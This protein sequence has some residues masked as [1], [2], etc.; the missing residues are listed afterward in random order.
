MNNY[1]FLRVAAAVPVVKVADTDTNADRICALISEA[2]S[3]EVS[4]VVFPE[5]SVTGYT[6]GDLFGQQL[7]VR[8][9]EKGCRQDNGTY[10]GKDIT[11]V[12]GAPVRFADRLY[13]CAVVIRNGNIKALFRKHTSRHTTNTM[14][15]AGSLQERI[16]SAD[17]HRRPAGTLST[18]RHCQGRVP[19]LEIEYAGF[20]CNISPD[21]LLP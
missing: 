1:G 10:S 20:R 17:R 4:L 16:F 9:A 15:R 18:E 7:L 19:F 2:S 11:A 3:R 5:L 21:M 13:N 12:V 6:C 8:K 14:N